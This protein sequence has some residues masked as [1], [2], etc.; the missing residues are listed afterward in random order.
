MVF[1]FR[2]P[3]PGAVR[4]DAAHGRA[5]RDAPGPLRGSGAARCR[6]RR[7]LQRGD[8]HRATTPPSRPPYVEAVATARALAF[9]RATDAPVYVVHLSS[10]AA[11][12]EVRRARRPASGSRPRRARTSWRYRRART[13]SPTRPLRLLRDLAAAALAAD[14]EALWAALADGTLALVATDHVP[15]RLGVEKRAASAMPFHRDQQR[16]AGHRD[17]AC[18][19]STA[20]AWP[21][22]D[23]RSSAWSTCC[24][25]RPRACSG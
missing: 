15:D 24:R 18:R 25:P 2:L 5:R 8:C 16:R 7:S 22:A 3:R 4:C 6:H 12:D 19:A 1:D 10:A 14:R 9:A 23:S 20:R 21:A 11:L 13:T 17:A